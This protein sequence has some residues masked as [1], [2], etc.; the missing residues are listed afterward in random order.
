[1]KKITLIV[2]ALIACISVTRVN[3]QVKVG[4]KLGADFSNIRIADDDGSFNEDAEAKRLTAPR[5]GFFVEI[6]V[7]DE[8][9]FV[10]TGLFGAVKG[11][12]YED[13]RWVKDITPADSKETEILLALDIPINFGYKYDLGGAK[14]FGMAGPVISY[15]LYT[16]HLYEVDGKLN[17]VH[18]SIGSSDEDTYKALDFGVNVEGGI[19]VHRFQ[20]SLFYNHGLANLFKENDYDLTAKTS[21]FGIAAAIKFGSVD[22]GRG[23]YRR[24]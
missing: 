4:I 2:I 21:V 9:L 16:T 18:Q 3:A 20:F 24:R 6:P 15:N 7:D 17:N 14:L 5:L 1:M 12:T 19:E 11:F 22:S 8:N 23:G 10:H 13:T